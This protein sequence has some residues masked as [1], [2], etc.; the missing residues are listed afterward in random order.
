MNTNIVDLI[1]VIVRYATD[2][3]MPFMLSAFILAVIARLLVAIIIRRQKRFVI[4][5]CKRVHLDILTNPDSRGSFYLLFKR[6]MAVTY[7]ESFE[8][9]AK[10]M[11]RNLDHVMTIADRVFLIQDGVIRMVSDFFKACKISAKR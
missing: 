10:Y 1:N 5:F 4:E 9:R 2:Y 6:F 7:F 11:R 3:L 8:L